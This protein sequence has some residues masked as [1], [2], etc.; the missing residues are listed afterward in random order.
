MR[1]NIKQSSPNWNQQGTSWCQHKL[2]FLRMN[3]IYKL[4]LLSCKTNVTIAL[5]SDKILFNFYNNYY[6]Y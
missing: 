5:T 2:I 3:I 1:T 6:L 4:N